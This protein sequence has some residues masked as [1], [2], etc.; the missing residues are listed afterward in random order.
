MIR[1]PTHRPTLLKVDQTL[2]RFFYRRGDTID[3]KSRK[4]EILQVLG[5]G[6]YGIVFKVKDIATHEIFALKLQSNY[7]NY[8]NVSRR[9]VSLL[10]SIPESICEDGY[11][12]CMI[13]FEENLQSGETAILSNFFAKENLFSYLKH[14]DLTL[15]KLTR[16]IKN[17]IRAVNALH[18]IGIGHGDIKLDNFLVGED[19]V[20]I[21]MIDL[22]LAC[23]VKTLR[24]NPELCKLR[25]RRSAGKKIPPHMDPMYFTESGVT[26]IFTAD[27]YSLGFVFRQIVKLQDRVMHTYP[28]IKKKM[29]I[30]A[31][32]LQ[33]KDP[34]QRITLGSLEHEFEAST[35]QNKKR[36]KTSTMN[37][38]DINTVAGAKSLT[39]VA[40]MRGGGNPKLRCSFPSLT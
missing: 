30:A 19:G 16:V 37:A 24:D 36:Q 22:G 11:V 6:V 1:D 38:K 26:N 13:D 23:S 3:F 33:D 12:A 29:I 17:I 40:S 25:Y 2:K 32:K 7:G 15:P 18:S 31:Q 39:R 5:S 35:N 4:F 8:Q 34:N 20:S 28:R 21:A 9:E 27:L 14:K 10:S